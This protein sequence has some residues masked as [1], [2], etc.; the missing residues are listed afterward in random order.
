MYSQVPW[1]ERTASRRFEQLLSDGFSAGL[2]LVRGHLEADGLVV[3]LSGLAEL[4]KAPQ[5]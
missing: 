5:K 3:D 1:E 4:F 2:K